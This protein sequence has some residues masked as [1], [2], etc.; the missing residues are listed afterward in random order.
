MGA[1]EPRG[2]QYLV[3]ASTE[4][5]TGG[6]VKLRSLTEPSRI[7]SANTAHGSD[8]EVRSVLVDAEP[9]SVGRIMKWH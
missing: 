7:K 4:R 6:R 2:S 3:P 5:R 9:R 8:S 1:Q